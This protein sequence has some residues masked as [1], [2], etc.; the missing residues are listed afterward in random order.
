MSKKRQL[1][2]ILYMTTDYVM[3]IL[4]WVCFF[5]FRSTFIEKQVLSIELLQDK[6][7]FYGISVIPISWLLLFAL[8][9]SYRNVYQMSRLAELFRSFS[10]ILFGSIALFFTLILDDFMGNFD[11]YKG[12]YISFLA[13][14]LIQF[15][16]FLCLDS[17]I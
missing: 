6:N 3:A 8:S 14:F 16:L 13:L 11:G 1:G 10:T 15:Y 7:F 17:Y 5:I 9:D 12:Y 2:R 4:G